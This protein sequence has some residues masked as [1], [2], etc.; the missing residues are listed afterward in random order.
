MTAK[1][2]N[3]LKALENYETKSSD[4]NLKA[5]TKARDAWLGRTRR[6]HKAKPQAV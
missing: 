3:L 2:Q 6:V 5:Y 1:I 4:K